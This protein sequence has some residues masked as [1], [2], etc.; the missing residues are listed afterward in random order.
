MGK[1]YTVVIGAKDN[2]YTY[3]AHNNETLKHFYTCL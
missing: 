1:T 3:T 2:V